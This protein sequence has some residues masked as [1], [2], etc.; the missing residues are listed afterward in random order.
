MKEHRVHK[1]QFWCRF[2]FRRLSVSTLRKVERFRTYEE[3]LFVLL[4]QR[5]EISAFVDPTLSYNQA[6]QLISIQA[7][8]NFL[9]EKI[10]WISNRCSNLF[11]VI[12]R[13]ILDKF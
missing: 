4:W 12:R 2:F 11:A 8:H 5:D 10:E 3:H 9:A 6:G 7:Q 1:V 13:L